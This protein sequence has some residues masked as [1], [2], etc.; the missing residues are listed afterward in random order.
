MNQTLLKYGLIAAV[1]FA[2]YYIVNKKEESLKS[3][4]NFS[5]ACGCGK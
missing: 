3:E 2:V 1:G 5:S 4:S